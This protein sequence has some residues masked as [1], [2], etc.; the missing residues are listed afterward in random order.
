VSETKLNGEWADGS[1]PAAQ[2]GFVAVSL[3]R[4]G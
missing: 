2:A 4:L 1:N 3:R